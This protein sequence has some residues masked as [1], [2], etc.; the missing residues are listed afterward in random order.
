MN[1][2]GFTNGAPLRV[3]CGSGGGPY[4]YNASALCGEPGVMACQDPST[5][6]NWDG[7]HL[8]EAAYNIIATSWLKG[9]YADPPILLT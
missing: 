7:I 3:C 8:T 4:N 1:T 5:Y 2:N 6:V 9:P